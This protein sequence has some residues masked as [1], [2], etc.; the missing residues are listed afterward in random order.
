MDSPAGAMSPS[1]TLKQ[2]KKANPKNLIKEKN[3][4]LGGL[5]LENEF[6]HLRRTQTG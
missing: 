6:S 4:G 3:S 1:F 5:R 2:K